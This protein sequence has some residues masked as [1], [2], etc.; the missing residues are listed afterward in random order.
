MQFKRLAL[1]IPIF[2]VTLVV[3]S[4]NTSSP[5]TKEIGLP[6]LDAGVWNEFAGGG[7]TKCA[8]GSD[9]KYYAYKGSENKVVIDF[10][11]GG[12][13]WDALSCSPLGSYTKNVV[14]SPSE[15]GYN[16]IYDRSN[17][18]NP[19]KDWFHVFT[20]YCTGDIHIGNNDAEYTTSTVTN[21]VYHR[22][23][24]NAQAVLD[25]TFQEFEKPEAIFVTGCSA[26]AYGAIAWTETIRKHYGNDVPLYQLGDCGAG[27]SADGFEKVLETSWGLENSSV[28][29]GKDFT[30]TFT[31]DT[32]IETANTYSDVTLTQ[33]NTTRDETQVGFYSFGK[34]LFTPT[35]T[36]ITEWSVGLQT[37]MSTIEAQTSSGNNFASYTAEY[38]ANPVTTLTQHCV[39]NRP[40]M[41][42]VEQSGSS[43]LTWITDL[44]NGNS[45]TSVTAP[46]LVSTP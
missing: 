38:E 15:I 28:V 1:L 8:D 30:K 3:S 27:I 25:W 14:G 7:E 35:V 46:P 17:E 22:G 2:I 5:T 26:G 45:I 10:Q 13:C 23:A 12:A 44:V 42:T 16:G 4:C 31:Q 24:I 6:T 37:S 18:A 39:I 11:G 40:D 41:Y 36:E 19:I 33:Y 20:P 9:Y 21:T 32:Y 43:L 29:Q 34:G